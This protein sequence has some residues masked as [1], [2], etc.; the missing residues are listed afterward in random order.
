[1]EDPKI[2]QWLLDNDFSIEPELLA[3][4]AARFGNYELWLW[5][6]EKYDVKI[7]PKAM[8]AESSLTSEKVLNF[9]NRIKEKDYE[10]LDRLYYEAV[11]LR[12]GLVPLLWIKE[13]R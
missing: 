2:V 11:R 12:D 6:Y 1:M 13:K 7:D 4:D 8:F 3:F 5:L 10:I 9:L